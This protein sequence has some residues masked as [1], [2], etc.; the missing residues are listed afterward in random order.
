M[1]APVTADRP[2]PEESATLAALSA[3]IL[4]AD[5]DLAGL[6]RL[7]RALGQPAC[8]VA[9]ENIRDALGGRCWF[10]KGRHSA[11]TVHCPRYRAPRPRA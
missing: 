2:Q 10:C 1:A 11:G 3:R 4:A 9:A 7:L 8:A 6:A 5:H